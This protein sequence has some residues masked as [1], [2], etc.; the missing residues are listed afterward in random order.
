M[1]PFHR[2]GRCDSCAHL[3]AAAK[4]R[5]AMIMIVSARGFRLE[6]ER[7]RW[8]GVVGSIGPLA[9]GLLGEFFFLLGRRDWTN[10]SEETSWGPR[11]AETFCN[12]DVGRQRIKLSRHHVH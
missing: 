6:H 1:V 3:L 2:P 9:Y 10:Q 8:T 4:K 11:A 7:D 12:G 5:S